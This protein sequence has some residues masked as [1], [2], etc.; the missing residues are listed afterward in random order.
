[1]E[2]QEE[3]MLSDFGS[4]HTADFS[5]YNIGAFMGF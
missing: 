1:M 3:T 2:V 4:C 5:N